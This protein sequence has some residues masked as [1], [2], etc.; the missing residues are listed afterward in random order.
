MLASWSIEYDKR[1]WEFSLGTVK[2]LILLKWSI[3]IIYIEIELQP[4]KYL[5]C[6]CSLTTWHSY[7]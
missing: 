7:A 2:G 5:A 1:E 4:K 6:T 3:E